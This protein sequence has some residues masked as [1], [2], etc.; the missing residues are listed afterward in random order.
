MDRLVVNSIPA[1]FTSFS[2]KTKADMNATPFHTVFYYFWI[3]IITNILVFFGFYKRTFTT[4]HR[5]DGQVV[6]ITGSTRGMGKDAALICSSLGAKVIIACRDTS[7]GHSVAQEIKDTGYEIPLVVGMDLCSLDSVTKAARA[8]TNKTSRVDVLIN[9][10]GIVTTSRKMTNDSIESTIQ[11]NYVGQFLLTRALLPCLNKSPDARVVFVSSLTHL[12]VKRN[13]ID[14]EDFFKQNNF[15]KN[16]PYPQSKVASLMLCRTL[17]KEQK[18][19]RFYSVDPGIAL[20]EIGRD[21]PK[22]MQITTPLAKP[23]MRTSREAALAIIGPLF[24]P[25]N[26]YDPNQFYFGDSGPKFCSPL[27][28]DDNLSQD[29]HQMTLE[30]VSHY[31][32]NF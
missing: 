6:V 8:I 28:F 12:R 25:K 24:L 22:W 5:L 21:L 1:S 9:N 17:A 29:L 23:I 26:S 31:L 3:E 4:Q 30:L 10:A 2:V 11:T 19:I 15:H 20:T 16:N 14:L 13:V 32:L 7:L 27:I 18:N